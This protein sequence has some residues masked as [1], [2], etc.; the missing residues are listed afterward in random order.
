MGFRRGRGTVL[1]A[2]MIKHDVKENFQKRV[3][4]H[5]ASLDMARAFDGGSRCLTSRILRP[6]ATIEDGEVVLARQVVQSTN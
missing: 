3:D 4:T 2:A 6:A 1:Q 5:M